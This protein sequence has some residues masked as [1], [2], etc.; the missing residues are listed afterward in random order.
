M[1]ED[2]VYL[3]HC[4]TENVYYRYAVK[5]DILPIQELPPGILDKETW[6]EPR[7]QLVCDIA[8]KTV[9][10]VLRDISQIISEGIRRSQAIFTGIIKHEGPTLGGRVILMGAYHFTWNHI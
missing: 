7:R 8:G 10:R 2:V 9:G 6:G 3:F 1:T 4:E 5:I